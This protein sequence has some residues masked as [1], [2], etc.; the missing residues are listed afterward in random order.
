MTA[1]LLSCRKINV[2]FGGVRAVRDVSL[3]VPAHQIL[4]LIGPNGSGKSTFLNA[5]TGLVPATGTAVL[6]GTPLPLGNPGRIRR[7][8]LLRAF[9]TAQNIGELTCLENVLLSDP[10]RHATGA[11]GAWVYRRRMWRRE[12]ARWGAAH[13]ALA[14]VGLAAMADVPARLLTYGQQRLVELA[15]VI[16]GDPTVILLDEP[17]AGLNAAETE[18]LAALLVSLR[19]RGETLVVVDHK[20]GF[21]D[22]ICDRLAVLQL[23]ELIAEGP[24]ETVWKDPR[25][26]DAYIGESRRG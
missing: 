10:D 23:G 7:S 8:G 25:V 18:Q 16:A 2:S 14:L 21:L 17:S 26:I 19:D 5:I 1:V 4:G 22:T 3:D 13:D 20:I 24:P 6:D 15:R 12:R 9:Q 11:A